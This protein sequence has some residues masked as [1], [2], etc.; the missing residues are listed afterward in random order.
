MEETSPEQKFSTNLGAQ[1]AI[2]PAGALRLH[3]FSSRIFHNKR[4]L[5][6][7]VPPGYDLPE[8]SGRRYPVF[9]L[10]DG[11]NL[12][13]SAT[14]FTG[15]EWEV[16]E[17]AS[18]MIAIGLIPPMIF[19]GIDNGRQ[20]RLKEYIP[21]R[22]LSPLVLRPLGLKYPDFLIKEVMPFVGQHYRV[23]K[24]TENTGFGGSSLGGLICLYVA[25]AAPEV[26][27]RLLVESPSLW[28]AN[29]QILRDARKLRN[30]PE[31]MVIGVGTRESGLE[32]K[33]RQTVENVRELE[34]ILRRAGLD[35]QRLAVEVAEGAT[36]SE[37]AWAARFPA[38]LTFL[39]GKP[40]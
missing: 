36:H 19:V 2:S 39:F 11:Q 6:V 38:A 17:T 34:R 8:N 40:A 23:G 15:V 20:E 18:R 33:D 32:D 3:E 7:W 21:Y 5:R 30:W 9:Y 29:Q 35:Q 12:F 4:I 28:V 37:G 22:S 25:T 26:F 14:S 24:G 16:D 31:K 10:N 13:E 1:E 27:G